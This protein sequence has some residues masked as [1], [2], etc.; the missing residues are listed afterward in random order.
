MILS[1]AERS[2]H[3]DPE[4]GYETQNQDPKS[5]RVMMNLGTYF[6][7]ADKFPSKLVP[8]EYGTMGTRY[9]LAIFT[10]FTTSSVLR[11]CTTMVCGDPVEPY[12]LECKEV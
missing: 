11:T 2:T 6:R 1:R 5:E 12:G 7:T 8:P 4:D 3:I 9:R 10:T